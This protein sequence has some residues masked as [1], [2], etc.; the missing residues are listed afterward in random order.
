MQKPALISFDTNAWSALVQD[1]DLFTR[2]TLTRLRRAVRDGVLRVAISLPLL[3]ELMA[4]AE[5]AAL[6]QRT[7]RELKALGHHRVLR[8]HSARSA[9][10]VRRRRS[11]RNRELFYGRTECAQFFREISTREGAVAQT[12]RLKRIKQEFSDHE[13]ATRVEIRKLIETRGRREWIRTWRA[14]PSSIIL[15]WCR[16]EIALVLADAHAP[17]DPRQLPSVWHSTAYKLAR[18]YVVAVEGVGPSRIDPNDLMDHFH[19]ADAA[20]STAL[21]TDDAHL[22]RVS[23]HCPEPRIRVVGLRD[24]AS[25]LVSGKAC[26]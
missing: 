10:E 21:I 11:L 15:D 26:G 8:H 16:D 9:A 19:Y 12:D 14:D 20:Y 17:P 2:A 1:D 22:Q 24:W 5:H 13:L 25:A 3:M 6:W 4:L 23:Q 18:I 7:L